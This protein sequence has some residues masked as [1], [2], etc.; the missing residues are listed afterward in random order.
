MCGA[1]RKSVMTDGSEWCKDVMNEAYIPIPFQEE[2]LKPTE[3]TQ[4][5]A[6]LGVKDEI[7]TPIPSQRDEQESTEEDHE[8][9]TLGML[10]MKPIFLP[11]LKRRN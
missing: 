11:L 3:W 1:S 9:A 6:I 7:Y 10:N 2:K 4:E 8:L 5:F